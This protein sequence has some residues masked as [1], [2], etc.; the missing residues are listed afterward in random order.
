MAE[1]SE[2]SGGHAP[3]TALDLTEQERQQL[4]G[5]AVRLLQTR[6]IVVDPRADNP[7]N[8]VYFNAEG[9]EYTPAPGELS[10]TV[11]TVS[12]EECEAHALPYDKVT[13]ECDPIQP[14]TTPKEIG[15]EVERAALGDVPLTETE[16]MPGVGEQKQWVI[17]ADEPSLGIVVIEEGGELQLTPMED[18]RQILEG[19]DGNS[20]EV[21]GAG[22]FIDKAPALGAEELVRLSEALATLE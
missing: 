13:F 3:E 16:S 1:T 22:L 20:V 19:T 15:I 12:R 5:A 10:S 18:N 11:A 7:P 9:Q 2:R 4:F 14:G 17:F 6:G 8:T 21:R